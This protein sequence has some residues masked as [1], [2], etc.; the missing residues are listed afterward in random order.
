M[1]D[2]NWTDRIA[3]ERMQVDQQFNDQVEV[4]SF[5]SQQWGLVMTAVEFEIENADDPESARIVANTS[6][7]P[8]IM[9]ELDRI[10]QQSAMGGA[11]GG[12]SGG[13]GGSGGGGLFSGVKDALGL[14]GGGNDDRIEEAAELAQKY[15]EELQ[16]Q[17]ESNGRWDSVREQA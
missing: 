10:E 3:A 6:K 17:L 2:S 12:G 13:S 8:S 7:L 4:S 16:E 15:A 14:G 5:S 11:P 1:S 9:P